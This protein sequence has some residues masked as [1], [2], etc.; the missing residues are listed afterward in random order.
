VRNIVICPNCGKDT[1]I[2]DRGLHNW[3]NLFKKPNENQWLILAVLL[4]VLVAALL[5]RRDMAACHALYEGCV[6]AIQTIPQQ[7]LG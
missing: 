1:E 2:K 4:F 3:R 7:L 5:Y 6:P